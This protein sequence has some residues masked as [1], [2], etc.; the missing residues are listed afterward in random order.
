MSIGTR[1]EGKRCPVGAPAGGTSARNIRGRLHELADRFRR[2]L[3]T[4]PKDEF[5]SFLQRRLED[6]PTQSCDV[7]SLLLAYYLRD[8]GFGK[9]DCMFG[10]F[11]WENHA[12][13]EVDGFAVDITA[14]QFPGV[15][16]PIMVTWAADPSWH[17][18]F[19]EPL[20][21]PAYPATGMKAEFER[22]YAALKQRLDLDSSSQGF[23][24][25]SP[26]R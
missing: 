19:H 11:D 8:Q 21:A 10:A 13:L 23:S 3:L 1:Y 20:R 18:K 5:S 7:A 15:D 17:S 24:C 12:W 9:V 14:D 2:A 22:A 25:L 6:F 4:C 26:Y 16:D